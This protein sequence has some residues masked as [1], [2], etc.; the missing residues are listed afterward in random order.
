MFCYRCGDPD[1][2]GPYWSYRHDC[3][4]DCAATLDLDRHLEMG[5]WCSECRSWAKA[6]EDECCE[7]CGGDVRMKYKP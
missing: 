6:D 2:G 5:W 4:K 7:A 1:V 3:C